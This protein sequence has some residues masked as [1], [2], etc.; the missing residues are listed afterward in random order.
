MD[1]FFVGGYEKGKV[2]RSKGKKM[3]VVMGIGIKNKG[4]VLCHAL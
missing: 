2:G 4:I 3:Q 1:E